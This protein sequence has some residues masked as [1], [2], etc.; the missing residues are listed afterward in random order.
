MPKIKGLELRFTNPLLML[1]P[2]TAAHLRM[3]IDK[4]REVGVVKHT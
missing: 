2:Q 3:E 1:C 4:D